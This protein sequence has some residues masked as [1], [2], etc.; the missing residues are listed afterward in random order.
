MASHVVGPFATFSEPLDSEKRDE[1]EELT[2]WTFHM[3][4]LDGQLSGELS[5][6][7]ALAADLTTNPVLT[8]E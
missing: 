2:V 1:L 6:S 4:F 3:F 7:P 8:A 5:F